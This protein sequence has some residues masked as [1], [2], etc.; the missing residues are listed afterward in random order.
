MRK[1][2]HLFILVLLIG[3]SGPA[4]SNPTAGSIFAELDR[5]LEVRDTVHH[6]W[7][8]NGPL[9]RC[10]LMNSSSEMVYLQVWQGEEIVHA[11]KFYPHTESHIWLYGSHYAFQW[12]KVGATT[13]D[14]WMFRGWEL[15]AK[16]AFIYNRTL[17]AW[18]TTDEDFEN[19]R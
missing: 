1:L 15:T 5:Q 14:D 2:I 16:A 7:T 10:K 8:E 13:I 6:V 17:D 3:C 4:I 11:E 18:E 12:K 19:V 9:F